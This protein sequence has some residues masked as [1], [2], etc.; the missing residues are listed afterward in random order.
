MTWL[1][2]RYQEIKNALSDKTEILITPLGKYSPTPLTQFQLEAKKHS[3]ELYKEKKWPD[4]AL[5]TLDFVLGEQQTNGFYKPSDKEG[6]WQLGGVHGSMLF[7]GMITEDAVHIESHILRTQSFR[8]SML[9]QLL[10]SSVIYDYI[11]YAISDEY[12]IVAIL[13]LDKNEADPPNLY[14]A[15]KEL[16]IN[17]NFYDSQIS[18]EYSEVS[19]LHQDHVKYEPE[20]IIDLKYNL[21]NTELA[22]VK[23][24]I[25]KM[26]QGQK[27]LIKIAYR[28]LGFVYKMDYL[29][30]PRNYLYGYFIQVASDYWGYMQSANSDFSV[31]IGI[32]K[33]AI[34]EIPKLSRE[35][36]RE[37]TVDLPYLFSVREEWDPKAVASTFQAN[38][39][40]MQNFESQNDSIGLYWGLELMLGS[41][42]FHYDLSEH[43]QRWLNALYACLDGIYLDRLGYLPPF[44]MEDKTK[45]DLNI[46]KNWLE[47]MIKESQETSTPLPPLPQNLDMDEPLGFVLDVLMVFKD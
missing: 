46:I 47:E 33:D 16:C 8:P 23:D 4:Y 25:E 18:T 7:E 14:N 38:L 22:E 31:G 42:T 28:L 12:N 30:S 26:N 27:D 39:Q 32:L 15:L 24:F 6:E 21:Y 40:N 13:H 10:E 2:D 19:W 9:R 37:E 41:L 3:M 44:L 34:E 11:R 29:I 17:A 20:H 1:S 45:T 36:F 35:Q 5:R 43:W